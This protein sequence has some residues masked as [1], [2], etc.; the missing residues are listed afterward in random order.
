MNVTQLDS[1]I[2]SEESLRVGQEKLESNR[3]LAMN[4]INEYAD[5]A[6]SDENVFQGMN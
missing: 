1:N 5:L 2:N 6:T 3:L 4:I